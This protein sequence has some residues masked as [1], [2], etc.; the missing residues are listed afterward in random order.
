MTTGA[1]VSAASG[2]PLGSLVRA[3]A[4]DNQPPPRGPAQATLFD[5]KKVADGIYGAI[6]RPTA[7]LNCIEDITEKVSRGVERGHALNELKTTITPATL[8]SLKAED[9]S[10][11]VE[12]ELGALFPVPETPAGMLAQSV[13]SNVQEVFNYFTKRKGKSE[14]PGS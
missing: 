2:L 10:R 11:R 14:L 5:L 4:D 7:M 3:I 1:L 12:R 9:M 8:M 13:G 6:A